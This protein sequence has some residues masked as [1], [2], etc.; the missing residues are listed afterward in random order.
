MCLRSDPLQ[1]VMERLAI[2]GNWFLF[3]VKLCLATQYQVFELE[4]NV[5]NSIELK[6]CQNLGLNF[7]FNSKAYNYVAKHS[8]TVYLQLW[9]ISSRMF[10][11]KN[12]HPIFF[13]VYFPPTWNIH[14][15]YSGVRRLVVVEAG[16]KRVE[17]VIS[18]SD[19][20][21]FLLGWS[22]TAGQNYAGRHLWRWVS[23]RAIC[24]ITH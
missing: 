20:F 9:W 10:V 11:K 24:S 21:R 3:P 8:L 5:C 6:F 13:H 1:K 7:N 22:W 16:S 15:I 17:G 14:G 23:W 2:P 4:L 18:L 12:S 19:I